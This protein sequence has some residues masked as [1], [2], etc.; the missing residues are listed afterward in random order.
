MSQVRRKYLHPKYRKSLNDKK[1][2]IK[3]KREEDK[4][5]RFKEFLY[6]LPFDVK[7]LI[8]QIAMI[9]HISKWADDLRPVFWP[10]INEYHDNKK[11][12]M[13]ISSDGNYENFSRS[14]NVTEWKELDT[15]NI[16]RN[17]PCVKNVHK[18]GQK[19]I[20]SVYIQSGK[21]N[22]FSLIKNRE[23]T[24]HDNYYWTHHKCRC[25]CCDLIRVL[26][27]KHLDNSYID[28]L[29]SRKDR[30]RNKKRYISHTYRKLTMNQINPE[31]WKYN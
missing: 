9:S 23:F 13:Y 5:K 30:L 11:G 29:W 28:N 31:P 12:L 16:R 4:S 2:L 3:K 25:Y 17:L 14:K 21:V 6:S 27:D 19:G 22:E 24:N 1:A 18:R 20:V 10:V 15:Y 8:F 7:C 26:S